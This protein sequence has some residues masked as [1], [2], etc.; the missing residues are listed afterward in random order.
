MDTGD[1][2]LADGTP[3]GSRSRR[4]PGRSGVRP[5]RLGR[6]RD[7]PV[8]PSRRRQQLGGTALRVSRRWT[9]RLR[10]VV[11]R[12]GPVMLRRPIAPI[13]RAGWSTRRTD[14]V[15]IRV[16]LATGSSGLT[17]AVAARLTLLPVGFAAPLA[18]LRP[19]WTTVRPGIR[20]V[21]AY[22][23]LPRVRRSTGRSEPRRE[24]PHLA[25]LDRATGFLIP[26]P[27]HPART[28]HQAQEGQSKDGGQRHPVRRIEA[29]QENGRKEHHR[30]RDRR[31]TAADQRRPNRPAPVADIDPWHIISSDAET[32]RDEVAQRRP[33]DHHDRPEYAPQDDE[34]HLFAPSDTGSPAPMPV[35]RPFARP[36]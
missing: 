8:R 15:L 33:R 24:Q 25:A 22:M 20:P 6:R 10:P 9:R 18:L 16:G 26:V 4:V 30:A 11:L 27:E 31:Q 12:R 32:P 17:L 21:V 1:S 14:G 35:L 28:G 13:G 7:A 3:N 34:V 29:D 19:D 2:A 23:A 36:V 5:P